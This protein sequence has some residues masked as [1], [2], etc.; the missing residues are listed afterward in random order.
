M[1][2]AKTQPVCRA[3]SYGAHCIEKVGFWSSLTA[4][5]LH[6][7]RI[8]RSSPS[9]RNPFVDCLAILCVVTKTVPG[10]NAP[11]YRAKTNSESMSQEI[12][13]RC[14]SRTRTS[15]LTRTSKVRAAAYYANRAKVVHPGGLKPPISPL[16]G[17]NGGYRPPAVVAVLQMQEVGPSKGLEPSLF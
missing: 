9:A 2:A 6:S 4:R 12:G 7:V 16:S 8:I 14:E 3:R 10:V 17:A 15:L 1:V 13:A 5:P 11:H